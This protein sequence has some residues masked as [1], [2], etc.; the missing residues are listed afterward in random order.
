[1]QLRILV[2]E[3]V[4]TSR[5]FLIKVLQRQLPRAIITEAE[6][7]QEAL[8]AYTAASPMSKPS[9]VLMDKEMPR[10][11]GYA[12]TRRLRAMGFRGPIIGITGDAGRA[13]V[14][15]F[16]AQGAV[17]VVTKPVQMAILLDIIERE[18]TVLAD[19]PVAA[20][21]GVATSDVAV[22]V[23][24]KSPPHH[25]RSRSSAGAG[26][27]GGPTSDVPSDT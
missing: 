7:G 16:V 2:V 24:P 26:G 4:A 18:L 1:V 12:A 25:D 11:D 13:A 27:S 8:D 5:R 14:D 15:E 19:A 20:G 23:R 6:D 9:V 17:D 10:M 21:A 3:D 22:V